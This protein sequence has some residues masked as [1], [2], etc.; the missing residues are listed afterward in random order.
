M[1]VARYLFHQDLTTIHHRR[2]IGP[3]SII[4][5][6]ISPNGWKWKCERLRSFDAGHGGSYFVVSQCM[7]PKER[8]VL[9][10]GGVLI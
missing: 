7:Q 4:I 6:P 10:S 9:G 8:P 3:R 2:E 5:T 1:K